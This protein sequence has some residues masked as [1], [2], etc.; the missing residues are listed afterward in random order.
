MS[1]TGEFLRSLPVLA[2]ETWQMAYGERM[3]LEG[4]LSQVKPELAVEIGTAEGGSLRRIA[5]HAREVHAF[6]IAPEVAAVVGEIPHATAHI[7][8]SAELLPR[9][10]ADLRAAGRN[11]DFALVDGSHTTEGVQRDMRALLESA[12]CSRTVVV[13]HDSANEAVRDGLEALHLP[14]Y[15]KVTLCMLDFVPGYLVVE[16]HARS[17]E[18]W[19]GLGLVVLDVAGGS[20][21]A[22]VDADHENVSDVYRAFRGLTAG[23]RRTG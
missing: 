3:A 7:G 2:D 13:V 21:P 10:L 9:V 17:R 1:D 5:A 18:I 14:S 6:D 4:I 22:T 16:E 11:V 19:N 8:D 20:A 23:G 15:P 12:A